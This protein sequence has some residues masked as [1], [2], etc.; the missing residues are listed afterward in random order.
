M[1][2]ALFSSVTHDLRTPLASIKA[3]VSGLL[4]ED[5]DYDNEQRIDLLQTILEETDRLNRVVGNILDLARMRAGVLE[6]A[7]EPT[8]IDEV[9]ES[10]LVR[11]RAKLEAV[12]VK[13]MFRPDLPSLMIDPVQIDQVV[14]NVLENALRFSPPGGEIRISTGLV[15]AG[16]QIRI[17]D[18]GP[19]IAETDRERVFEAFDRGGAEREGG[20]TGLGLSI[21]RAI[22]SVHGGRIWIEGAP[23]GGTAVVAELPVGEPPPEARAVAEAGDTPATGETADGR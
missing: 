19:G 22:V 13:T 8:H 7:R 15:N 2:A 10:V 9:I 5:V 16:V 14:T 12:Q 20:G 1:R 21:A 17:A 23:G 11:M 3:A 6:P 4:D 18:Q